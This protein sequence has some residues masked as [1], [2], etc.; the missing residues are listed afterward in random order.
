MSYVAWKLLWPL[1]LPQVP[2]CPTRMVT[3]A[4]R[5]ATR[6]LCERGYVWKQVHRITVGGDRAEY[7]L[8]TSANAKTCRLDYATL[9]GGELDIRPASHVREFYPNWHVGEPSG[10]PSLVTQLTPDTLLLVP[11]PTTTAELAVTVSLK[12]PIDAPKVEDSLI[13]EYEEIIAAGALARLKAMTAVPWSNP[14]EAM[15][16]GKTFDAAVT[17]ANLKASKA[18]GRAP[19]RTRGYYQ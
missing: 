2:L 15:A 17:A 13:E 7:D 11:A 12:P 3:K 4:V 1:V 16:F 6:E 19:M 9:D 5:N 18:F 10:T 8:P 14:A